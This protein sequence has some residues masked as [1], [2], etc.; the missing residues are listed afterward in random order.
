ML[1]HDIFKKFTQK[2]F[3]VWADTGPHFRCKELMHYFF[4]ELADEKIQISLNFF[5]ECHGKASRDSH[6]SIIDVFLK[7]ESCIKKLCSTEDVINAIMEGQKKSNIRRELLGLDPIQ[8]LAI[9]HRPNVFDHQSF[10]RKIL[11][12]KSYY[13][14]FTNNNFELRSVVFSDLKKSFSIKFIDK[15]AIIKKMRF[16]L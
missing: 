14:F 7:Q 15:E 11:N 16:Y 2:K 12:L 4:K 8:T 5:C 6:F 13:N 10:Y 9:E 3:I 1:S